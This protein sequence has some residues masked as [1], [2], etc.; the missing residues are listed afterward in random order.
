MHLKTEKN[1][2]LHLHAIM[3]S[4]EKSSV[5]RD[6]ILLNPTN[7][8]NQSECGGSSVKTN[9]VCEK[10]LCFM[11]VKLYVSLESSVNFFQCVAKWF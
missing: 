5:L 1:N 4:I 6:Q 2:C 10:C 7:V 3:E 9:L 11:Q 8:K